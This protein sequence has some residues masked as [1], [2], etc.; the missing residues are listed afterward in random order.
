[1]A[2]LQ[3]KIAHVNIDEQLAISRIQQNIQKY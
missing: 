1:M 2:F 3:T